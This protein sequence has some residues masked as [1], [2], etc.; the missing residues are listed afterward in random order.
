MN[1]EKKMDDKNSLPMQEQD[2]HSVQLHD[3][4]LRAGSLID[5]A[6]SRLNEQQQQNLMAKAAEEALRLEVK[7]REQNIDYVRGRKVAEDHIDTF[8]M[9]EKGGRT[10]RQ[11]VTSDIKTGAGNMRI[12]SKSGATCFV[13]S[14]AYADPNHPDVIFLRGF[15][16]RV[17][18]KSELGRSFIAWYWR[19][20]P[21]LAKTV[22]ISAFLRKLS[23]FSIQKLVS[24]LKLFAK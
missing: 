14:V 17:L 15:R 12:E 18:S 16:D 1:E 20:G 19:T 3:N 13:A 8:N 24:V 11:T 5:H 7:N 9:L 23:K 6:L 22:Y 4:G 10:T 21:K 2:K